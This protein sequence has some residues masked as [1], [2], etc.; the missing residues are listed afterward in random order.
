MTHVW[1]EYPETGGKAQFST[2]A[3]DIWRARGW[4]DAE[5]AEEPNLLRDP[6]DPD[7]DPEP[8]AAE[9]KPD[10]EDVADDGEQGQDKTTR[11]S[12]RKASS[13]AEEG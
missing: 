3:A 13:A 11:S 4:V 1:L 2:E 8:D 5:P 10:T 12:R 7:P 6:P 9:A